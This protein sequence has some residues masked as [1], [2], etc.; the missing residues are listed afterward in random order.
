[1]QETLMRIKKGIK[2]LDLV[3]MMFEGNA[4]KVKEVEIQ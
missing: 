1:M 3:L 2:Q 4:D